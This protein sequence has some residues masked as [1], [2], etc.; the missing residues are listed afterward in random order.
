M[1]WCWAWCRSELPRHSGRGPRQLCR[2]VIWWT[3][4]FPASVS[5]CR[6]RFSVA[7]LVQPPNGA[8]LSGNRVPL[9]S[10]QPFSI[11]LRAGLK[12]E[13]IRRARSGC[14]THLYTLTHGAIVQALFLCGLWKGP[15]FI[16]PPFLF[17]ELR[18]LS[19]EMQ[20]WSTRW[21]TK[22]WLWDST[23]IV[24][25]TF[26]LSV[27]AAGVRAG[28]KPRTSSHAGACDALSASYR[29]AGSR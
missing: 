1:Q 7:P 6:F 26:V 29:L 28:K 22:R 8:Q 12:G 15:N 5:R 18:A 4:D 3:E 27:Q 9:F 19:M 17:V 21:K 20:R 11:S 16:R 13:R 25:V 10:W 24:L 23:L 2:L 14:E